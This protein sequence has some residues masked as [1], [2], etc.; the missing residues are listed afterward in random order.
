MNTMQ[1]SKM[2]ASIFIGRWT[3]RVLFLLR[4]GPTDTG[5][6]AGNWETFHNECSQELFAISNLPA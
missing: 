5:S 1:A 4:S 2:V 6:S 3:P